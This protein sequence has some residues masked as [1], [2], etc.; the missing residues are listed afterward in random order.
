MMTEIKKSLKLIK[1]GYQAKLNIGLV[2]LFFI[3]GVLMLILNDG[4]NVSLGAIY[5]LLGPFMVIQVHYNLLH[6]NIIAS[7]YQRRTLDGLVPNVVGAVS[8]L[9]V[10]A[11]L[12]VFIAIKNSMSSAEGVTY[13]SILIVAS[14]IIF[15]VIV[16]YGIAYKIFW[17]GTGLFV[18]AFLI[19]FAGGSGVM[20]VLEKQ[21]VSI[22]FV[23][24]ALIGLG[25]IIL[26]N[27]LSVLLRKALY[28]KPISPASGGVA[29]RKAMQ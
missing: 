11:V 26:G 23:V 16:Y 21:G 17:V 22:P 19:A 3:L 28:K 6:S 1:Y 2:V 20:R 9:I 13:A 7:S 8:S 12:V 18:V 15:V 4:F 14:L 29:L 25:L 5:I 24:S 27:V 10:Y